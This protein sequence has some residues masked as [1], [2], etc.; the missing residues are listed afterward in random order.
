MAASAFLAGRS[1]SILV[2]LCLQS[3]SPGEFPLALIKRVEKFRFQKEGRSN[4]NNIKRAGTKLKSAPSRNP[5]GKFIN[6]RGCGLEQEDRAFTISFNQVACAL[7]FPAAQF[8]PK[9]A[10]F[11]RIKEFE[12]SEWS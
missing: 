6:Q 1:C 7:D 4:L 12:F 9:A 11:Q 2:P 8:L 10:Q 5:G 3:L